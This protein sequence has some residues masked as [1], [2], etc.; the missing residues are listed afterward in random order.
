MTSECGAARPASQV[1]F[2]KPAHVYTFRNGL[3]VHWKGYMSQAD[4]LEAAGL[5]E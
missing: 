2:G 1:P 5:S 4:A 3:I